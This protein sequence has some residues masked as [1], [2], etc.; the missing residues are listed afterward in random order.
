[1]TDQDRARRDA[2]FALLPQIHRQ[3][4]AA[5][6]PAAPLPPGTERSGPLRALYAVMAAEGGRLEDDI[7]GLLDDWFIETCDEWVVPYIGDLLGIGGL[8]QIDA[9]GFSRRALVA[10]TLSYRRGKGV[11]RV[12]EQHAQDATGWRA[13]AREMFMQLG[14]TQHVNHPRPQALRTP[15]LRRSADFDL[16]QGPFGTTMHM[17]DVRSVALGRG[18]FNIQNVALFLWR[19][20]AYRVTRA[21]L[22]PA[23][24]PDAWQV[25]PS[26]RD[27]PLF[28]PPRS[29]LGTEDRSDPR[30][31]PAPLRRRALHDELE[32]RR[33]ALA[34]G[35]P[36]PRLWFDERDEARADPVLVLEL[37]AAPV[38]PERLAICDL[39]DWL[40]PPDSRD[41]TAVQPDGSTAT[42]TLPIDAAIDP[43]LGRLR[44]A[45]AR[46]GAAVRL[47]FS[48]GFPGD[49]GAGSYGRRAHVD[50]LLAE[51]PVTWAAGIAGEPQNPSANIFASFAE[52]LAEWRT[53]PPGGF[54]VI[55]VMDSGRHI[56][57]LAGA[58]AIILPEGSRLLIVA[59]AWPAMQDPENPPGVVTRQP[60]R[61]EP[62]GLRPQLA[63]AVEIR[64]EAPADSRTPGELLIDGLL[65]EGGIQIA[66]GHLGTLALS[67]ATLVPGAG[68]LSMAAGNAELRIALHRTVAAAID[69]QAP[70]QAL[71]ITDSIIDAAP[72]AIAA[73]GTALEICN[74]TVFGSTACQTIEASGTIFAGPVMAHRLQTGCARYCWLPPGSA[75]PRRFRCQ[76]DLALDGVAAADQPAI[77]ARL[78]PAFTAQGFGAPGYAQLAHGCASEIARGGEDGEEMGAWRFLFQP[79]RLSN[80]HNL[81]PDYLPFGLEA[82]LFFET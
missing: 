2:L 56:E 14:T 82:G 73:A 35:R 6:A 77:I 28:N 50:T 47:T 32:A 36:P 81:M 75:T 34:E 25:D 3:R 66:D 22:R 40:Q 17:V 72:D 27:A 44:L 10:N 39:S 51:R 65:I 59:A 60:G 63:G 15:D 64:G 76:P 52:A 18:R 31:V 24:L 43:Q 70:A 67:H 9:P 57:D 69:L 7:T 48:H 55:A 79:Q 21:E 1:M 62:A 54:G 19:L 71:R 13:V 8:Q 42:V 80:L 45:P 5:M 20:Q 46:A 26:G 38:P 12:L 68:G 23:A 33:Q 49:L 11:A 53:Q 29:D 78:N 74:S 4:D 30:A 41:Y 61:I 37:D 58:D 16:A